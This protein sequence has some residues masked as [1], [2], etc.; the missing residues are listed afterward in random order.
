MGW[1]LHPLALAAPHLDSGALVELVPGA[2]LDVALHWQCAR[3]AS[4]VLEG[5]SGA[6]MG[7]AR[8]ALVQG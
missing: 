7:A 2:V 3:A 4:S 8:G 5:L 1:G 6:V